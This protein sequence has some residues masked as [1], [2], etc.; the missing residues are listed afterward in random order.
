MSLSGSS[1]WRCRSWATIRLA[2][3]SVT[4][5]AEE[6]DPLVQQTRVDVERALPAGGLLDD[7]G[8]EWA[9]G[10]ASLAS[11]VARAVTPD[12][13]VAGR[14]SR[15]HARAVRLRSR[16]SRSRPS[17]ARRPPSR[18][19]RA[20]RAPR[21]ARPGSA[22][23]CSTTRSTALRIAMSSRS[24]SSAPWARARLSARFSCLSLASG[25]AARRAA[26]RRPR[27]P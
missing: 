19:S 27:R 23:A 12:A 4:G 16:A 11:G 26:P 5:R 1:D 8:D 17:P 14:A 25:G 18:A 9:H 3:S 21:P 6:D 13:P 2:I 22:V 15:R 24:A 20:S 7:H 10:W